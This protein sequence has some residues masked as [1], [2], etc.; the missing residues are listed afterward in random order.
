VF[1]IRVMRIFGLKMEEVTGSWRKLHKEELQNLY[2]LPHI[3]KSWER[4]LGI[5]TGLQ[6]RLPGFDSQQGQEI[7]LFSI[8]STP[9]MGS[10]QP[11]FQW[12]PGAWS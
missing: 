7:F 11:P 6:A 4:S 10:T 12:I 5:V 3:V 1:E 9:S 2:I 8:V